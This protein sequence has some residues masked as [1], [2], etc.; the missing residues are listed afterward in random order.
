LADICLMPQLYNARRWGVDLS[1]L[2]KIR[3]IEGAL[4]DNP[5]FAAAHPDQTPH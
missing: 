2:P 1:P 5:A 4:A 3:R